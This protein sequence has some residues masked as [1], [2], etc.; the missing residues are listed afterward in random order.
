MPDVANIRNPRLGQAL[1]AELQKKSNVRIIEKCQVTSFA[2]ADGKVVA[3]ETQN[4]SGEKRIAGNQIILSTGAWSGL[5]AQKLG[6]DL[7]VVPVKGQMLLYKFD[8]PPVRTIMLSN[9]RYVIPRQDGYLLV[10]S[11]LEYQ[12]FDKTPSEDALV[13]LSASG[14][15]LVPQ[16]KLVDPVKQ[17]AGLRPG[18]P[19]GIPYIGRVPGYENVYINAGQF[20]NGLVLAPASARLMAD[21]LLDREPIVDPAPYDPGARPI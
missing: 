15:R 17:W 9:G 19:D 13:S 6:V 5:L 10:G 12:D 2:V 3:V 8:R 14:R 21:I 4:V 7:N 1:V 18:A 11:T 16:L 20:R